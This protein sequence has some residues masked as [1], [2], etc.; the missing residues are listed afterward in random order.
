MLQSS[1]DG[2]LPH[3]VVLLLRRHSFASDK[4][5]GQASDEVGQVLH[6]RFLVFF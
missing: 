1:L 6:D 5:S 4:V 2:G 3:S